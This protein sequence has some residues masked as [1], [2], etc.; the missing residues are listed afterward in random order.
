M[1]NKIQ[2]IIDDINLY[3]NNAYDVAYQVFNAKDFGIPQ[4]RERLFIIGN[5]I[6]IDTRLILT[7]INNKRQVRT[8]LKDAI[9]DLPVLLPKTI[10]NKNDIDSD[11]FGFLIRKYDYG[12]TP[13]AN[14]INN[15]NP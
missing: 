8:P 2:E 1:A 9:L 7:E 11:D 5:R 14:R 12:M 6:G 13:F 10:K 4:N 3:T 15:F